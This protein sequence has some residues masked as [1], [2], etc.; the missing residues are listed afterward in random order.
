MKHIFI[1]FVFVF[2]AF[3]FYTIKNPKQLPKTE[4]ETI[5]NLINF[6][7]RLKKSP[8]VFLFIEN[9]KESKTLTSKAF[10]PYKRHCYNESLFSLFHAENSRSFLYRKNRNWTIGSSPLRLLKNRGYQIHSISTK[11][12]YEDNIEEI[13]FGKDRHLANSYTLFSRTKDRNTKAISTF[14]TLLEKSPKKNFFT[15]FLDP[16]KD[17]YQE[18]ISGLKKKGLYKDSVVIFLSKPKKMG[19][20]LSY[21]L[22]LKLGDYIETKKVVRSCENILPT[23]LHYLFE[24]RLT[25]G[26]YSGDS[27]LYSF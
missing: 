3:Y 9:E 27:S 8:N 13:I 15:L 19:K 7:K 10:S 20:Y 1:L 21:S 12:L 11:M 25:A 14:K 6:N 22:Y 4:Q 2:G 16:Q 18:C 24:E 17:S 23:V 5:T 26:L